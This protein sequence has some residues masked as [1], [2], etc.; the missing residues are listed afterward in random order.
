M[1]PGLTWEGNVV[2]VIEDTKKF[3]VTVVPC[4]AWMVGVGHLGGVKA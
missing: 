4:E 3:P 2:D 1:G